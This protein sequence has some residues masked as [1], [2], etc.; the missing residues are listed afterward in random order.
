MKK[1]T[2]HAFRPH[3]SGLEPRALLSTLVV[4]PAPQAEVVATTSRP[5]VS[6]RLNG[7][8]EAQGDDG[9]PADAPWRFDLNGTGNVQ[10]LGRVRMSG[11]LAFGGFL[12]R[13]VPDI[14]GTITLRNDRGTVTIRL[15]G[16]GGHGQ[17]PE[18]QFALRASIVRG[19]GAYRDLRAIGKATAAFG[20]N[21]VFCITTP[22]P[23]SGTLG[24]K[25][26][27][28]RPVR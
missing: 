22:C 9:R 20:P 26:D 18:K 5:V 14:S 17:V 8:Y 15:T 3:L 28:F 27:L 12:P 19:T 11:S 7:R 16:S 13:G 1:R 24:L 21:E 23:P 2:T 25:L 4:G 10:G 6:G